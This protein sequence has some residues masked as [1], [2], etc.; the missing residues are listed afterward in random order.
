LRW[1]RVS[2]HAFVPGMGRWKPPIAEP[3]P[4][5]LWLLMAYDDPALALKVRSNLEKAIGAIDFET[6][7]GPGNLYRSLY[8]GGPRQLVRFLSFKRLIG[9]EELVDI[10]KKTLAIEKRY[11]SLAL[12]QIELD[13]GYVTDYSVVRSSIEEDFHRIYLFHGIYAESLYFFER[14]SY[15]SWQTTPEFFRQSEVIAV[16]NDLRGIYRG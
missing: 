8:G 15:R 10:R 5:R 7:A 12:P 2:R 9:R 4:G 6:D 3:P 16:F 13:P 14:L 11:Q 1:Q